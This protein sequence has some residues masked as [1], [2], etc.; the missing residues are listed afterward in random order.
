MLGRPLS[1]TGPLDR[2]RV[3]Y[4]LRRWECLSRGEVGLLMGRE[5][6]SAFVLSLEVVSLKVVRRELLRSRPEGLVRLS[7]MVALQLGLVM[8]EM[9]RY[10]KLYPLEARILTPI[11]RLVIRGC[12]GRL[13][14]QLLQLSE[15]PL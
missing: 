6:I 15:Y 13:L 5:G 3:F 9:D 10:R 11:L 12:S 4:P 7:L 1:V 8:I 2:W 14:P